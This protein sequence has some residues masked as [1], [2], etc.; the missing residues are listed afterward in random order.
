MLSSSFITHPA[1][2]LY[3]ES[4]KADE[5]KISRESFLGS[6]SL[7]GEPFHIDKS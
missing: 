2:T 6:A 1:M 4:E 7:Q 3:D 5:H